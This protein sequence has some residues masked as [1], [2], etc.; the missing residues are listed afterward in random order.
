MEN[1]ILIPGL[2]STYQNWPYYQITMKVSDIVK[3][4][5]TV[6][7]PNFRIKTTDEVE[8]IYS[9]EGIN[10]LLQR[11]LDKKRLEPIK[12][13][14]REQ[15]DA[16]I[17]NLTVAIFGGTPEWIPLSISRSSFVD[18]V[19][20]NEFDNISNSIGVIKL[21][22]N[23]TLFVLDGQH[24]LKA[25]RLAYEED[26]SIGDNQIAITLIT[27]INSPEGKTKTRRLFSVINRHAKPV[28]LGE[29]ILLDEDDLSAIIVRKVIEEYP[30]FT[31]KKIIALNKTADLKMPK[32]RDKFS[33]VISLY[34][35]NEMLIDAKEIYPK[36]TGA[37]TNLVRIRPNDEIIEIKKNLVFT[38][39]DS[40]FESFPNA[41][42]FVVNVNEN[43]RN[44][45]GAFSLR[46]IGQAIF[47]EY[48]LKMKSLDRLNEINLI[49]HIPDDLSNDFWHYVL[50]NPIGQTI[51]N[52]RSYAR[53]YV[54]YHLNL[55]L[56]PNQLTKLLNNY[57]KYSQ[58]P[59]INLPARLI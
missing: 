13:F 25:L 59:N 56:T 38:F 27:H 37:K 12:K 53:D 33:S 11:A 46:P 5:G 41:Q 54:Y 10:D 39:W 48:Y 18:E 20:E 8:I 49:Q 30:L 31:E 44:G 57:R 2:F 23:E 40:F 7:N 58:D 43:L 15:N 26:N 47:C 22:G 50:Y 36:Y 16:Y 9:Q 52:N 28:S 51:I 42:N 21:N 32:D 34:S 24:R 1:Q 35:I 14:I 45:V 17:N 3:N 4:L 29:N 19:S 6:E 55:P